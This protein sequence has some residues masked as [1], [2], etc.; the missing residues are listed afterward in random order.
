MAQTYRQSPG[1]PQTKQPESDPLSFSTDKILLTV[2]DDAKL[3]ATLFSDIAQQA[4][5][6]VAQNRKKN[7]PTQLR[8]FY[9][10]ICMWDNKIKNGSFRF[11]VVDHKI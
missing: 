9:D 3:P 10:E 4:A 5:K 1:R 8:K 11:P 7:K 6:Y 2:S